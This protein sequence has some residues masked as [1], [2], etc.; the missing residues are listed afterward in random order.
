MAANE[1]DGFK[2]FG[3]A[4]ESGEFLN[5]FPQHLFSPE[6]VLQPDAVF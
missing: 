3:L 1:E 6:E 2:L 5:D 4:K